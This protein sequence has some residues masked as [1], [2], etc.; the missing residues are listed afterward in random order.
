MTQANNTVSGGT[1]VIGGVGRITFSGV[2]GV[3]DGVASR[4]MG[5][6]LDSCW[7]SSALSSRRSRLWLVGKGNARV[8]QLCVIL[9]T[10]IVM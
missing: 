4:V 2:V 6:G 3:V 5:I 8:H 7:D 9:E 10:S 1:K